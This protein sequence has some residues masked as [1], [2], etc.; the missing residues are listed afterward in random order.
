M[1][2]AV[3]KATRRVL[4]ATASVPSPDPDMEMTRTRAKMVIAENLREGATRTEVE[5]FLRSQHW[6]V[7][8]DQYSSRYTAIVYRSL[9]GAQ[10]VVVSLDVSPNGTFS[11]SE[12][13]TINTWL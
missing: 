11:K 7:A 10:A 6:P 2:L 8:F 4:I 3:Q 1:T 12:V 9:S 5:S 13:R